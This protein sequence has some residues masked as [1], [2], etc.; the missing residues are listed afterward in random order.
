MK[1]FLLLVVLILVFLWAHSVDLEKVI[2]PDTKLFAA[3]GME[4]S[5]LAAVQRHNESL[6]R[7]LV[8]GH[9]ITGN[10]IASGEQVIMQSRFAYVTVL[11]AFVGF[12]LTKSNR[13]VV[14]SGLVIALAATMY[15]LDLHMADIQRRKIDA[16]TAE[17]NEIARLA[18][19]RPTNQSW[20]TLL[21]NE[22]AIQ[23]KNAHDTSRKRK[24]AAFFRPGLEQIIL[25][26]VLPGASVVLIALPGPRGGN[27]GYGLADKRSKESV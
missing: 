27:R 5:D 22:M 17:R 25:F 3:N 4:E 16:G 21:H 14:L 20:H 9:A 11:A 12:F 26:M 18:D 7:I 1:I 13:R 23:L 6:M 24:M 15:V 8:E 10:R 2:D 19:L